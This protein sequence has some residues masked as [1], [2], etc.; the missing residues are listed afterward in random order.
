M[1]TVYFCFG[2]F[3]HLLKYFNYLQDNIN[4]SLI[5]ISISF[6][7]FFLFVFFGSIM[8]KIVVDD[9]LNKELLNKEIV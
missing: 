1:H 4:C 3:K 2:D 5:Y 6:D 9:H 7:G 8:L